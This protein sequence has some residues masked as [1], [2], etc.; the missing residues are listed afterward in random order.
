MVIHAFL[1]QCLCAVLAHA[2]PMTIP[3]GGEYKIVPLPLNGKVRAS[4][5][6][7]HPHF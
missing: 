5:P 4:Q 1:R 3:L 6:Q 2:C 7:S